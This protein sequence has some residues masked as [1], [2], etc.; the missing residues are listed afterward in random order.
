MSLLLPGSNIEQPKDAILRFVIGNKT[1]SVSGNAAGLKY[2]AQLCLE[3]TE[4]PKINHIHL[5]RTDENLLTPD[6]L[7]A[8]ITIIK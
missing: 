6:S 7:F 8:S 4:N 5:D 1:V 2:L 3:L